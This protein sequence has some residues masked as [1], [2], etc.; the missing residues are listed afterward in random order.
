MQKLCFALVLLVLSSPLIADTFELRPNS[1]EILVIPGDPAGRSIG[2]LLADDMQSLEYKEDWT[3]YTY[4]ASSQSYSSPSSLENELVAGQAFWIIQTGD[5]SVTLDIPD[6][7]P[8]PQPLNDPACASNQGCY[9]INL[10][11]GDTSDSFHLVGSPFSDATDINNLRFAT[12]SSGA[13]ASGCD[14]N[15]AGSAEYSNSFVWVYDSAMGSYNKIST[16]DTVLPWQGFWMVVLAAAQPHDPRLNF[17]YSAD[18]AVENMCGVGI[19]TA[20]QVVIPQLAK[21]AYL[22]PYSDPAF[23]AQVT[24]ITQSSFGQVRKPVYS[25]IQ[26]WNADESLLLLYKT[27]EGGGYHFLV[28]G[29]TYEPFQDLSIF[30]SDLE[31]VFW[32]HS[33][34]DILYYVSRAVADFGEFKR[35]SVSQRQS[36]KIVDFDSICATRPTSGSDVHMQSND[37]DLFGFRCQRENGQYVMLSYR[38]S[39]NETIS[40]PIGDGTPWASSFAPTPAPSGNRFWFQGV[41]LATNLTSIERTIDVAKSSEHSNVGLTY[42]GQDALFQVAFN[43]SPEGCDG[44]ADNGIGHFVEHNLETGSCRSFFTE[45]QGYPYTTSSTHVSAQSYKQPGWIAVSSI[46][47]SD[48]LGFFTNNQLAPTLLSE[49]YLA[50]TDPDDLVTCRL[51][52]HRS[53]GKSATNGEY[54]PYFGE[55]HA[56]I[57]PSGTRIVFG[58]DWYDSGSVDTYV[59]ELPGFVRRNN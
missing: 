25:T 3:I 46:G 8:E 13:C 43:Q 31:E 51:A 53:F 7:L 49:I 56:S 37:D 38:V 9:S 55:P 30:P 26:A 21:P 22:T 39:T 28:D 12:Q 10:S 5:T 45:S 16:G 59:V 29:Q 14:L 20:E 58:S 17:P 41:S 42:N 47:N 11:T 1:W 19:T 4:N 50:N 44:D 32:S 23:G 18:P 33:D 15:Q 48:Q 40:S 57:S 34:P 6:S 36:T 24:R 2:E 52:H 35:Y 27:G 54:A